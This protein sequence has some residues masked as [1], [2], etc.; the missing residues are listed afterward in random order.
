MP[1]ETSGGANNGDAG[2]NTAE[3]TTTATDTVAEGTAT[4]ASEA[5]PTEP[6]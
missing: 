6:E 1:S 3:E 4:A 2:T 5:E